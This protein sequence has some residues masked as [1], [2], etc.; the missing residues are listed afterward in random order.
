V[1]Q[2]A[3]SSVGSRLGLGIVAKLTIPFGVIFVSAMALLGGISTHQAEKLMRGMLETRGRVI[4]NTLS[5]TLAVPLFTGE[6]DLLRGLVNEVASE[7]EEIDYL[8]VLGEDYRVAASTDAT[9][10]GQDL[11]RTPFERRVTDVDEITLV[12]LPDNAQSFEVAI[13]IRVDHDKVGVLRVGYSTARLVEKNHR[14]AVLISIVAAILLLLGAAVYVWMARLVARPLRDT[15]LHLT[16]LATADA[17]LSKRIPV[18]SADETGQLAEAFNGFLEKL[19][20]LVSNI[21]KASQGVDQGA[22]QVLLV[23]THLADSARQTLEQAQQVLTKSDRIS[24]NAFEA[25]RVANDARIRSEETGERVGRLA[26]AAIEIGDVVKLIAGV[27]QKI[28]LISFNAAIEAMHAGKVGAGFAIVA[29]EVKTLARSTA[30]RTSE[31]RS[32]IAGVQH[33]SSAAVESIGE[34]Q[35]VIGRIAELQSAIARAVGSH[36]QPS[37]QRLVMSSEAKDDEIVASAHRVTELAEATTAEASQA[38]FA[39]QSLREHAE[40][41]RTLVSRFKC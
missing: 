34:I 11:A 40:V 19:A 28:N 23:A 7:D 14:T 13:P 18:T 4:A 30:A 3:Q 6:H 20:D 39:A 31:I 8:I 33:D 26:S 17:D 21:R 36:V 32:R 9:L 12:E 10:V 35:A 41:L 38:E 1:I 29:G 16:A 25:E 37:E 5:H 2:T 27:A 24:R 15:V 22:R